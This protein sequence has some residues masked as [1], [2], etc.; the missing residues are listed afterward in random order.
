MLAVASKVQDSHQRPDSNTLHHSLDVVQQ[1][2][3]QH[4]GHL[5]EKQEQTEVARAAE[6]LAVEVVLAM[7][8]PLRYQHHHTPWVHN[9]QQACKKGRG[10]ETLCA[11]K[12]ECRQTGQCIQSAPIF[13]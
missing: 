1:Q 11:R 2:D 5:D 4:K 10:H 3:E 6:L 8:H 12:Q 7:P 13:Q 9:G